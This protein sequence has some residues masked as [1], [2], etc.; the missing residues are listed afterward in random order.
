MITETGGRCSGKE[1]LK[2]VKKNRQGLKEK[3]DWRWKGQ[4]RITAYL[5]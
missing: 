1:T 4:E 5:K 3:E 2:K